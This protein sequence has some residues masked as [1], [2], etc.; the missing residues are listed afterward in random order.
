MQLLTEVHVQSIQ[1][2]SPYVTQRI[3]SG[4]S[5]FN[6]TTALSPVTPD[7]VQKDFIQNFIVAPTASFRVTTPETMIGCRDPTC[8]ALRIH[9][10]LEYTLVPLQNWS[11][12]E[13]IPSYSSTWK[14]TFDPIHQDW[15]VFTVANASTLQIE[16]SELQNE[17]FDPLVDCQIYR[18]PYLAL[19]I[20]LKQGAEPNILAIGLSIKILLMVAPSACVRTDEADCFRNESWKSYQGLSASLW[21]QYSQIAYDR[22]DDNILESLPL[23]AGV[24]AAFDIDGLFQIYN[25]SYG[26]ANLSQ[27]SNII[28]N[29]TNTLRYHTIEQTTAWL[30]G[31]VGIDGLGG[32]V[33]HYWSSL[34]VRTLLAMPLMLFTNP[35]TAEYITTGSSAKKYSRLLIPQPTAYGFIGM[36]LG[37]VIWCGCCLLVSRKTVAPNSSLFPEIDFGSKCIP[38]ES[39]QYNGTERTV[40]SIGHALFPL[41]NATSKEVTREL[42]GIRI[43]AG[44]TTIECPTPPHVIL[45]MNRKGIGDLIE[46]VKYH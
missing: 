39:L 21:Q 45:G 23:T 3:I 46:G 37:I 26:V 15:D 9:D 36:A 33:D 19:Q 34:A 4:M 44:A 12:S 42:G 27:A 22:K 1:T 13:P 10:L 14:S 17:S 6:A 41:S 8:V 35:K 32:D 25:A 7:W 28:A 24:P 31:N 11:T 43:Y 38:P 2:F 18:Y 30:E 40:S 5:T 16:F 29:E 20:C